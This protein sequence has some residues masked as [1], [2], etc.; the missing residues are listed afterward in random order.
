MTESKIAQE[1]KKAF[2]SLRMSQI[3]ETNAETQMIDLSDSV[4]Q[5]LKFRYGPAKKVYAQTQN[6]TRQTSLA[7]SDEISAADQMI[8]ASSQ[9][10]DADQLSLKL[11]AALPVLKQEKLQRPMSAFRT[12]SHYSRNVGQGT[13]NTSQLSSFLNADMNGGETTISSTTMSLRLGRH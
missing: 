6:H 7:A 5:S 10:L 12:S 2:K 9:M 1:N 4:N 11:K 8:R 3:S 13:I